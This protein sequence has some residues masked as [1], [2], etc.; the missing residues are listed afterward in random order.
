MTHINIMEFKWEKQGWFNI[1]KICQCH[2]SYEQT[3]KWSEQRQKNYFYKIQ[4][5]CVIKTLRKLGIKEYV[6]N[7]IKGICI[8]P[9]LK[10]N[11]LGK[12]KSFSLRL[13]IRQKCPLLPSLTNIILQVLPRIIDQKKKWKEYVIKINKI[14]SILRKH[15]YLCRISQSLPKKLLDIRSLFSKTVGY[16]S[17]IK[18]KTMYLHA[19]NEPFDIII[20]KVP[21]TTAT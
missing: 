10:S 2:L 13:K 17:N 12:N 4:H 9:E 15:D 5:L 18:I 6:L 19:S 7:L 14:F 1:L 16:Q 8:K 20:L 3:K 11:L 21:F